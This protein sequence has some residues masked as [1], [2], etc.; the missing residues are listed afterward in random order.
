MI[1]PKIDEVEAQAVLESLLS[2]EDPAA[3]RV[4]VMELVISTGFWYRRAQISR[5]LHPLFF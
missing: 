2:E 1:P 3:L 5:Y 4:I